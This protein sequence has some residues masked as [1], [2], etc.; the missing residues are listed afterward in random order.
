MLVFN[1]KSRST[2]SVINSLPFQSV[3]LWLQEAIDQLESTYKVEGPLTWKA[4]HQLA[5]RGHSESSKA[6]PIPQFRV[7]GGNKSGNSNVLISPFS[8]RDWVRQIKVI[9]GFSGLNTLRLCCTFKICIIGC[10]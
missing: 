4:F 5:G 8:V 1:L 9:I 3:R 2:I 6:Q 10:F 7:G